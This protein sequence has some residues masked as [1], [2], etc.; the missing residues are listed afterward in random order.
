[1]R[2]TKTKLPTSEDPVLPLSPLPHSSLNQPSDLAHFPFLPEQEQTHQAKRKPSDK[3]QP[4]QKVRFY[5]DFPKCTK[6]FRKN[7]TL[8]RHKEA[9]RAPKISC[10]FPGCEK[11][12]GKTVIKKDI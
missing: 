5:C 8:N 4:N 6:S 10:D 12:F 1:M 7:Y 3:I 11:N 9:H 2:E